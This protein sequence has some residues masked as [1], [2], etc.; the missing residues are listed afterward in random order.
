MQTR[1]LQ[2]YLSKV[3]EIQPKT[4]QGGG[5]MPPMHQGEILFNTSHVL[6]QAFPT[7]ITSWGL[8]HSHCCLGS[9]HRGETPN[10]TS[11][12]TP[13]MRCKSASQGMMNQAQEA[14]LHL[15]QAQC[16]TPPPWDNPTGFLR[17]KLSSR[18]VP[19]HKLRLELA[20]SHPE[21]KTVTIFSTFWC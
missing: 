11:V 7:S 9:S 2:P 6:P 8:P 1:A 10:C 18:G 12:A 15:I 21:K 16:A 4:G 3:L 13:G 5:R 14:L 19:G 17:G 20:H